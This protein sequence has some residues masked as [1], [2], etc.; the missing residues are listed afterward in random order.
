M[1]RVRGLWFAACA[2]RG[3]GW[4]AGGL[5][6]AAGVEDVVMNAPSSASGTWS[7]QSRAIC[8]MACWAGGVMTRLPAAPRCLPGSGCRPLSADYFCRDRLAGPISAVISGGRQR[9]VR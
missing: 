7:S 1:I 8:R 3:S 2:G 9:T 4:L 6:V 5:V